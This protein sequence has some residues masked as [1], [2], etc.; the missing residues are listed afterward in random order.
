MFSRLVVTTLAA[1]TLSACHHGASNGAPDLAESPDLSPVY[2]ALAAPDV[3]QVVNAGGPVLLSPQV[4]VVTFDGDDSTAQIESF[5]GTL[6]ATDYWAATTAEYG[7][8]ALSVYRTIHIP[9][10]EPAPATITDKEIQGW[11]SVK[12]DPASMSGWPQPSTQTIYAIFYPATTSITQGA[13]AGAPRSCESFGGYHSD[14]GITT[15]TQRIVYAVLPRCTDP[16]LGTFGYLTAATS[17]EL[18]EASTD[19]YPNTNPAYSTVDAS[20]FVWARFLG[21]GETGDMCAQEPTAN[22]KREGF[23]YYV[24]RSWSNA[25]AA[26]GKSPCVPALDAPAYFDASPTTAPGPITLSFMG[27]SFET[28][29]FAIPIGTSQTI[30]FQL[31]SDGA[32]DPIT[33]SAADVSG[34]ALSLSWDSTTGVNGD[35]LHLTLTANQAT[36]G[37]GG[38]D[39]IAIT[40][41]VGTTSHYWLGV[42][43]S[44]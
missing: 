17:H 39:A 32:T 11:L 13:D 15:G 28:A 22:F 21:G 38:I 1:L 30:G 9:A 10:T 4:V 27:F 37:R 20:H 44:Q 12:L 16:Q 23:D 31:Y 5:V 24:Q 8:G 40:T 14:T 19:P 25:A 6:G 18:I 34:S 36:N 33:I 26:A 29:G 41:K 2:P 3:P 43:Q 35:T 7:V 42:V